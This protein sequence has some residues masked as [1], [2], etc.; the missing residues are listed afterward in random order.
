MVSGRIHFIKKKLKRKKERKKEREREKKT[1][2][3]S[4]IHSVPFFLFSYSARPQKSNT[5]TTT[6]DAPSS[7]LRDEEDAEGEGVKPT[8]VSETVV[9]QSIPTDLPAG[10]EADSKEEE[11][12][13]E[14]V[15]GEGGEKEEG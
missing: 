6:A 11:E 14:G 1:K 12:E 15:E 9:A 10:R 4:C 5:T 7:P 8:D 2:R 3:D 13:E